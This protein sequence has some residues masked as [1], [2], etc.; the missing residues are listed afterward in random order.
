MNLLQ[1][2]KSTKNGYSNGISH[3]KNG[4][5]SGNVET[6]RTRLFVLSAQ[7]KDGLKRQREILAKY[8]M[9]RSNGAGQAEP[10]S[11]RDLAFTLAEKRSRLSWRLCLSASS[12]E[13]LITNLQ[14]NNLDKLVTRPSRMPRVGFIFTG[15]GAQWA[16]MGIDLLQ[17]RIFRE[18]IEDADDY[19][20]KTL[21]C[22][23]SVLKEMCRNDASSN[24]NLPAYSQPLCTIL[25]VALVDLLESWN[26][27]PSVIAGH[28]SGEI[29]GAYCLGALTREDAWKVA[30]FR[31]LLSSQ[32]KS[33]SPPLKGAMLAV[34]VSK[35]EAENWICRY[36]GGEVV[37]ACVNSPT[38][39]TLSGST[40]GVN[41]MEEMFKEAGVFARKLKVDVAYHSPQMEMISVA[42]LESMRDIRT[43]PGRKDRK[44]YSAVTGALA[45]ASELGPINWVRNLVSPVLFYD[46]LRQ[47]LQDQK[48]TNTPVDILLEIGPHA[49]LRGPINQV[50]KRHGIEGVN[51]YSVLSRGQNAVETALAAASTLFTQGVPIDLCCANNDTDHTFQNLGRPVVD[52]P[53]YCWNHSRTYWAESRISKQ[54]RFREQ[55][56][57]SLIG[58]PCSTYGEH[59]QL[60]RGFLRLPEEPWVRDHKIQ[61]SILYPAAGYIAM[62]VEGACQMAAVGKIIHD[63]RMRD[64]QIVA[65]AVVSEDSEMEFILQLRPHYSGTRDDSSA[66]Q[67]FT[68]STCNNGQNLRKNCYGLLLIGYQPLIEN[69]TSIEKDLE[70]KKTKELYNEAAKVCQ[71]QTDPKVFYDDLKSLGLNYGPA[72]QNLS[73][74]KS[75]DGQSCCGVVI[76]SAGLSESHEESIRPHTIHP[77]TLDTMFHAVFAAFK[78]DKSQL[79]EAMVPKSIDEIT[80]LADTPFEMGSRFKG[81]ATASRHGFRELMG[82]IIMLDQDL[83]RSVVTVKNFHCTAIS[84]TGE[85]EEA[86]QDTNAGKLYSKEVWKPALEFCSA[87]QKISLLDSASPD[88]EESKLIGKSRTLAMYLMRQALERLPVDKIPTPHLRE[89]H[90]WMQTEC[91]LG[92]IG[93]SGREHENDA[94]ALTIHTEKE[95]QLLQNEIR[96]GSIENRALCEL[97]G[98]LQSML[99]GKTDAGHLLR[100]SGLLDR[101][102]VELQGMNKCLGKIMKVLLYN[103]RSI[104]FMGL[105]Y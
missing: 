21:G 41:D 64:V 4:L 79:R 91:S 44:M 20:S 17:Y 55:P 43:K 83:N 81:F 2:Q 29:A 1:T 30:Y 15:Q 38:S 84:G 24:I 87:A 8:L 22:T 45:D 101:I 49:A 85:S 58:A 68:V 62:A 40:S 88:L 66:W 14:N 42:Y 98:S 3:K 74:I 86:R 99:L 63:I 52:L 54:Y 100:Q 32:M 48:K 35:D 36:A 69:D 94:K 10:V 75:C 6:N 67:E 7:D 97:G 103:P 105:N 47:L 77:S 28:S 12:N 90:D 93:D 37:V 9:E 73:E 102:F 33:S 72:F 92:A 70:Q 65:P 95:A 18:S 56:R 82:D 104:T 80:I 51:T 19:L 60:W 59:E 89:L 46:A 76:S 78:H 34:G 71:T 26:I 50:M 25:Q 16:Q 31:G 39:V 11:L 5:K 61:T 96:N 57:R 53:S 13:T 27:Q 23:W